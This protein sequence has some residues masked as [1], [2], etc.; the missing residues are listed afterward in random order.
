MLDQL[1]IYFPKKWWYRMLTYIASYLLHRKTFSCPSTTSA[2]NVP[3]YFV[4]LA[5]C[6]ILLAGAGW[7][8]HT[9]QDEFSSVLLY[10]ME[11]LSLS[12]RMFPDVELEESTGRDQ[13]DAELQGEVSA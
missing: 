12:R 11:R 4:V 3:I 9:K 2:A 13:D 6:G 5:I 8:L 1:D 7:W 10:H